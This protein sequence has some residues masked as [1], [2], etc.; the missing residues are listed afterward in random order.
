LGE[1]PQARENFAFSQRQRF[2]R[3]EDRQ[4]YLKV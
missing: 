2:I 3:R 1:D 4:F